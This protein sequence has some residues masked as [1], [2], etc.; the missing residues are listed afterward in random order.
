MVV[1]VKCKREMQCVKTGA[2][3]HFGWGHVYAGDA[4]AC[5]TCGVHVVRTNEQAYHEED[6]AD[7]E[8]YVEIPEKS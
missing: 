5:P 1:C 2:R 4:F 8:H 7:Q 6:Y 3:V